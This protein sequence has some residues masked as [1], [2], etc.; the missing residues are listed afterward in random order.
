M[1]IGSFTQTAAVVMFSVLATLAM[2]LCILTGAE[3]DDLADF[4]TG[5]RALAPLT[6]GLAVA[7]DYVSAATVLSAS[8]IVALSGYDGMVLLLSTVL[9][10]LLMMSLRAGPLRRAGRFTLGDVLARRM[11]GRRVRGAASAVTLAAVLP[12][13]LVQLSVAGSL[14]TFI[15]GIGQ[16]SAKA[17]C[18]LIIGILM[19]AYA[20]V[21]GM[22]GTALVQIIKMVVLLGACLAVSVLVLGRFHWSTSALLGAA[23]SGSGAGA[24]FVHPGMEWGRSATGRIDFLS[25][26]LSVVL[27]AAWLPHVTMRVNAEAGTS[28][29][30]R[31]MSWAVGSTAVVALCLTVMGVAATALIGR[32]RLVAGDPQ[33]SSSVLVLTR[34]LGAGYPP[35]GAAVL[36]AAIGGAVF[37]TLL[38]ATSGLT[39]AAATSIAHDLYAGVLRRGTA[40]ERKELGAARWATLGV[41]LPAIVLA[42]L[43]R[44]WNL[45]VLISLGFCIGASAIAPATV[46][47]LMWPGLTRRGLLATLIG[48]TGSVLVL[49]AF[50]PAVSGSA[51]ALFP[52]ADFHWFPLETTGIVSVPVG[53]L[54]GALG[55]GPD[56]ARALAGS[57]V[58]AAV[59]LPVSAAVR[60]AAR[61]PAR[62]V[63]ALPR[64]AGR[65]A[66]GPGRVARPR[67]VQVPD[68]A[69]RPDPREW[70]RL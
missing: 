49:V 5:Y 26:Q 18:I 35:L 14:I 37:M 60:A 9:S 66:G 46:Y 48:G 53:F 50:S 15:L 42:V 25:L 17:V 36:H 12:F 40:L 57:A 32:A 63:R 39:L 67:R 22:K 11:P 64:A 44:N 23:E 61:F 56:A 38:S 69:G 52:G 28:A 3:S 43:V 70:Y 58:R 68:P 13:L 29:A 41:G 8:G 6:S 27:G 4:Y 59:R 45:Q 1:T 10:L 62:T 54:A 20:A 65:P 51:H 30:R 2:L 31:S 21:G 19:I 16:D 24:S 7:G 33:G 55:S 34:A 47:S